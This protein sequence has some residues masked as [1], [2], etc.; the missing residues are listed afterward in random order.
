MSPQPDNRRSWDRKQEQEDRHKRSFD[1]DE[2]KK[3]EAYVNLKAAVDQ[4]R[5]Y[6]LYFMR[7]NIISWRG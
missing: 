2:L 6:A 3:S 4:K 7:E 1:L 5:K